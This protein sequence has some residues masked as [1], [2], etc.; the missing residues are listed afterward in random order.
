MKM[1]ILATCIL[2]LSLASGAAM[3]YSCE[4][5]MN[6]ID[7]ALASRTD[8]SDDIRTKVLALR[9]EGEKLHDAGKHGKSMSKLRQAR[10]ILDRQ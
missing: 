3:A 9:D 8:I 7:Q 10:S 4:G 2:T 5:T 1:P 6:A